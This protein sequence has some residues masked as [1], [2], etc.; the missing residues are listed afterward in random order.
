MR[1]AKNELEALMADLRERYGVSL[2]IVAARFYFGLWDPSHRPEGAPLRDASDEDEGE[3]AFFGLDGTT[4]VFDDLWSFLNREYHAGYG[5]Q[6]LFGTVW[7]S[8]GS[9]II[10]GEYDGSEWWEHCT[11]PSIPTSVK[12]WGSS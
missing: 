6:Q 12:P 4:V 9:W 1:N 5:T 10:R 2:K 7:L 8:D 11:R 3:E